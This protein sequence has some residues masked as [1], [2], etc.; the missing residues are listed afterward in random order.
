[1][2][3]SLPVCPLPPR[4]ASSVSCC[5]CSGMFSGSCSRLGS[6]PNAVKLMQRGE[7][8]HDTGAGGHMTR[9]PCPSSGLS[10][11]L[12]VPVA[13]TSLAS[14]SLL[15]QCHIDF[16][17]SSHALALT[18]LASQGHLPSV[19]LYPCPHLGVCLGKGGFKYLISSSPVCSGLPDDSF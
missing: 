3:P 10:H 14:A 15:T 4:P 8:C 17:P 9:L 11:L 12:E 5:P 13:Q 16:L 1:M 7:L 6:G 18:T 2:P 19:C